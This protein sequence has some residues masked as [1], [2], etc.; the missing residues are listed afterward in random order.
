MRISAEESD[1]GYRDD[2]FSLEVKVFCDDKLV[3]KCVTA[4]TDEGFALFY[5]GELT[6][7]GLSLETATM[8]GKVEIRGLLT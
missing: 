5:A 8:R 4:D 6:P 2:V 7:D 3:E 1:P